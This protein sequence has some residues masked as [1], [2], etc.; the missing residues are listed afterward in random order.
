MDHVISNFVFLLVSENPEIDESN[1]A[2]EFFF[3]PVGAF[4]AFLLTV[5]SA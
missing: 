2:I 1:S 5:K 3:V 4:V